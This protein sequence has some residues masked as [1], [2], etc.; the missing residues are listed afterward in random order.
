M[1]WRKKITTLGLRSSVWSILRTK[2]VTLN[3]SAACLNPRSEQSPQQSSPSKSF[4]SPSRTLFG[5]LRSFCLSRPCVKTW[6]PGNLRSVY[7]LL[8]ISSLTNSSSTGHSSP[9]GTTMTIIRLTTRRT[10][11]MDLREEVGMTWKLY[12]I[13][14]YSRAWR[15]R[16]SRTQSLGCNNLW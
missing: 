9:A 4:P 3:S 5:S 15:G 1:Q 2:R 8:R 14:D 6:K 13:R 11:M 12:I 7:L 16:R 10:G